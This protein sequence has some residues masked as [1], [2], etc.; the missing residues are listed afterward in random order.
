MARRAR[1]ASAS[2]VATATGVRCDAVTPFAD[3]TVRLE[4]RE[5]NARV[6]LV[7]LPE[8]MERIILCGYPASDE[9]TSGT[10]PMMIARHRGRQAILAAVWLIGDNA[11]NVEFSRLADRDG[12]VQFEVACDGRVRR[13]SVPILGKVQ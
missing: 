2:C 5:D 8:V 7:M 12:H 13:H 11:K 3:G 1:V 6:R 4:R 9:P 10:V